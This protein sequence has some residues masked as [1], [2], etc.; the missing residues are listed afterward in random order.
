M[1]KCRGDS[2]NRKWPA[3]GPQLFREGVKSKKDQTQGER[4]SPHL[5]IPRRYVG[6]RAWRKGTAKRKGFQVRG[7]GGAGLGGG[8][9]PSE[10]LCG[11]L[12]WSSVGGLEAEKGRE[13]RPKS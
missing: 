1:D 6:T 11:W 2:K 4:R 8:K 10:A 12:T 5:G 9:R 7:K 3:M 13:L